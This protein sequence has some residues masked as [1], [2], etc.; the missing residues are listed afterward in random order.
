MVES[1]FK[2]WSQTKSSI[3]ENINPN[4]GM[5]YWDELEN[6]E[7]N[8]IWLYLKNQGWFVHSYL[9]YQVIDQFNNQYKVQSFGAKTLIHGGPHTEHTR[10]RECCMKV[11]LEDFQNIFM[12][13]NQDI[14]YE[15]LSF[16]ANNKI[17]YDYLKGI[18]E[19]DDDDKK[20]RYLKI[21]WEDF[22]KFKHDINDIF[23]QFNINIVLTRD[24]FVFRQDSKITDDIYQPVLTYLS[25][26]KWKAVNRDLGDAF[27]EFQ[28]K[29]PNGYSACITHTVSAL[30]AFMQ[31]IV[32]G[33][34]GKGKLEGLITQA[35]K[36]SLIPDD[37]FSKRIFKDIESVLMEERQ[38]TGNPH[39]K[40]EYANEKNAKLLLNLTMVFIQHCIVE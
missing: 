9:I 22:E 37:S 17:H 1:K 3:L 25:N 10:I 32:H 2:L 18:D 38:K 4:F 21:A 16:F 20:N 15:L 33:K 28:K 11:S 6:N 31:I 14:V 23:E 39:P 13:Q 35:I 26:T 27:T 36:E 34:T 30:Q 40:K 5:R 8:I 12:N 19:T 29:S 24:N 7:K